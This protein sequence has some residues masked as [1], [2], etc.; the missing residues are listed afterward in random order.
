MFKKNS[1][2]EKVSVIVIIA[3]SYSPLILYNFNNNIPLPECL[4]KNIIG[5]PCPGCGMSRA[6][7][8]LLNCDIPLSFSYNVLCIPFTLAIIISIIWLT[9]DV[10]RQQI[11]FFKLVKQ[12]ISNKYK[13]PIFISLI[14]SW[15]INIIRL[16]QKYHWKHDRVC[17]RLICFSQWTKS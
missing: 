2:G 4:F 15:V 14:I 17:H 8:A 3:L 5:L 7:L 12:G 16:W 11:T 6:T 10:F 13:F 1:L 9:V